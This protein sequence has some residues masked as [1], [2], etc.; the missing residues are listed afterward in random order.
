MTTIRS[1]APGKLVA[2][3]EYAVLDGSP[4]LVLAVDRYCTATL[5]PAEGGTCRLTMRAPRDDH[6][7]FPRG[8]AVG[9]PLADLVLERYTPYD[10]R[11]W[12]A[13]LDS[14]ELF[15]GAQ[16]LGLGSSAAAV[17]AWAGACAAASGAPVPSA[18]DLIDIHRHLQGGRGSGIDVAASVRGGVVEFRL[19]GEGVPRIGSVRLPNGVGFAGIFAGRSASTPALVARYRAFCAERPREA[20]QLQSRLR[21]IAETGCAAARED[22]AAAFIEA[23]RQYGR[24]LGDL[25]IAIDAQIVT[26]EHRR[27]AQLAERFAVAYKVSGAGGGD[28]GIAFSTD[29][30]SLDAFKQSMTEHPFRVVDFGLAEHGLAVEERS[31]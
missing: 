27:I 16:K 11:A 13:T 5:A 12:Q 9:T 6:R 24:V 31:E 7:A 17:T 26:A 30:R 10:G 29:A 21:S 3:G 18:A 19:A 8:S 15:D 22:D 23:V 25:G 2:L 28:L 20:A 14:A 1:R 4:A